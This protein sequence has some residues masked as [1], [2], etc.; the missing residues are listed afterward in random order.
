MQ[1]NIDFEN[2]TTNEILELLAEASD[3]LCEQYTAAKQLLPP[4]VALAADSDD[5]QASF[6]WQANTKHIP[7]LSASTRHVKIT[8]PNDGVAVSP[9]LP[10]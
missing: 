7:V 10:E 3:W 4:S 5:P 8:D 2:K 1:D 9:Q 6:F